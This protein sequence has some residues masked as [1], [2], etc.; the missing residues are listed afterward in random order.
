MAIPKI[1]HY[2]WFSGEEYPPLV[3]RCIRSWKKYLPDYEFCLWDANSFDFSSVPFVKEAFDNKKWAF[4]SDYIRL[5]ALYNYGGVYL[6]SDVKVHGKFDEW[7]NLKFFTGIETRPPYFNKYWIEA[8]IMGS[9]PGN[10]MIKECMTHYEAKPFIKADGSFDTLCAPNIITPVFMKHYGWERKPGTANLGNGI[11]VFGDNLI[12]NDSINYKKGIILQHRNNC[13][14]I[15]ETMPRGYLY[16]TFKKYG[17]LPYY[18][19]L[20]KILIKLRIH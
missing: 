15:E 1:I 3:K 19:R 2:C 10:S 8:A 5:Y 18:R 14:W 17:L 6:D 16:K 20:E 13:S 9:E 12:A 11:V 7:H 4:V